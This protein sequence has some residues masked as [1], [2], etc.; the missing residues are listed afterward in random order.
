MKGTVISTVLLIVV[1][2]LAGCGSKAP[3]SGEARQEPETHAVS[4][5]QEGDHADQET[6]E[7]QEMGE[8]DSGESSESGHEMEG[9]AHSMEPTG[10]LPAGANQMCPVMPDEKVDPAIFVEHMGKRIYVCCEKCRNRVREDPAAWYAKAYG[11][12]EHH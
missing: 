7:M 2:L 12:E 3:D 11:V 5:S 9:H 4:M 10:I 1:A 6:S 8:Q